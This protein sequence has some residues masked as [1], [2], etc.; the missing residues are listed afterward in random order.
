MGDGSGVHLKVGRLNLK[1]TIVRIFK[2]T[3]STSVRTATNRCHKIGM[4]EPLTHRQFNKAQV[5]S[6]GGIYRGSQRR[7]PI[8]YEAGS[9]NSH[10]D[11]EITNVANQI[12]GY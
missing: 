8:G 7:A 11:S 5:E 10:F 6:W 1:I 9:S 2:L 4:L 12:Q 3:S